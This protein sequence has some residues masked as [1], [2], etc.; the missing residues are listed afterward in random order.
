MIESETTTHKYFYKPSYIAIGSFINLLYSKLSFVKHIQ[1]VFTII[2]I[3]FK[4]AAIVLRAQL[5]HADFEVDLS[6]T[7]P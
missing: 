1:L 3:S 4:R 7:Q 6:Q 5:V 2:L